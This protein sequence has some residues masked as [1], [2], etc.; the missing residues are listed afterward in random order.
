MGNCLKMIKRWDIIIV[1]ILVLISF[2]PFT[3]FSA[4]QAK[5][6][7]DPDR[8]NIAVISVNNKVVKRIVLTG[9]VKTRQFDV[10][11]LGG[12]CNTIE[13]KNDQIRVKSADCPD[14]NCVLTGFI[15]KPGQTIVCLPHRL[16][17]EIKSNHA[18]SQEI[19]VSS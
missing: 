7:R 18:P 4:V 17:I 12:D 10:H 16:V 19:I 3:I 1:T 11:M 8:V 15:S 9:S 6:D 13:V 2:L 14:Q 5:N